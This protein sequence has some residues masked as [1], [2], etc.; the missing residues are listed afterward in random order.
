VPGCFRPI[1]FALNGPGASCSLFILSDVTS[2]A[3]CDSSD[4]FRIT[5]AEIA[6]Q[7]FKNHMLNTYPMTTKNLCRLLVLRELNNIC[8]SGWTGVWL[9]YALVRF[10]GRA[11]RFFKA[12][13][14]E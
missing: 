11:T 13:L 8:P 9:A 3:G 2:R 5:G 14:G 10:P 7:F 1:L 12:D 6:S 4:S